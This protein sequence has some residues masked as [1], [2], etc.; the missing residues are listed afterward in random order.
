MQISPAPHRLLADSKLA[1]L[2]AVA[3]KELTAAD[4]QAT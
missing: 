3:D 2:Y 4:A 1:Q